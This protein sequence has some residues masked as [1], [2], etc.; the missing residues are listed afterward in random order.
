MGKILITGATGNVGGAVIKYLPKHVTAVAGVRGVGKGKSIPFPEV[1]FD[2]ASPSTF[3]T[4]FDGVKVLFL[5]R[6]PQ[7][8]DSGIF[9]PLL[10][11]CREK[12]VVHV[13]FLSV[14]GADTQTMIPHYKIEQLILKSGLAYTFLRPAYFMEN[15]TTFLRNDLIERSEIFLPAGKAKLSIIS[16]DDVG[17]VAAEVLTHPGRY[18]NQ[19]FDL[20]NDELFSF[21]EMAGQL[22]VILNRKIT[23]TSPNLFSFF[24]RKKK[25][26]M[27]MALILVMI[28]LHFLPRFK[29]PP[30]LSKSVETILGH[31]PELLKAFVLRNRDKLT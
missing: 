26:G 16:L 8:S 3:E 9:V 6:P 31:R 11:S 10:E 27:P 15:F 20:T 22:S 2:F 28:M 29:K 1:V 14:Q 23:Y 18:R 7:L 24:L 4:A 19:A 25:E 13:V 12:G 21:V 30:V 5:L 17:K